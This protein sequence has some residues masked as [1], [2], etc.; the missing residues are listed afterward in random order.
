MN[1][2]VMQTR[3]SK[4]IAQLRSLERAREYITPLNLHFAGVGLLVLVNLYLL[5]HM[6]FAWQAA[7]SQDAT[8]V[9][10]QTAQLHSAEQAAQP[11]RGLDAK[12]AKATESADSFYARRLPFAGSQVYAELGALAKKQGVKLSRETLA[13]API[14]DGTAG[15]LTEVRMDASLVGEYRPLV[16]FLNSLER[17]RQFF[18]ITGV[19]LTG[20][21]S[22]TVNLRIKLTT[23][24]RA[25]QTGESSAKLVA[26]DADDAPAAKEPR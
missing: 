4:V 3:Q 20:Q 11:L 17:D 23:Y 1:Q 14:L 12:L 10:Q 9:A 22:G 13:Y 6:A 8:A 5:I 7:S 19:T 16:L 18:E 2:A 25:P 24:L 21:Q 26:A 15:A